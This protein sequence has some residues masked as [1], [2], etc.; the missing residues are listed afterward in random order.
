VAASPTIKDD[1][2]LDVA[3][4]GYLASVWLIAYAPSGGG[5]LLGDRLR[6]RHLLAILVVCWSLTVGATA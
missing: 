2:G 5:G 4:M 3:Q 6:A 1:L